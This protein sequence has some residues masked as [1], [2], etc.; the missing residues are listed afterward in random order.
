MHD[1]FGILRKKSVAEWLEVTPKQLDVM[2]KERKFPPPLDHH[3]MGE[4]WSKTEIMQWGTLGQEKKEFPT[5]KKKKGGEYVY[6]IGCGT[7]IK[8]GVADKPKERLSNLQT[9]NPIQ[10]ELIACIRGG[11]ELETQLHERFSSHRVRASGEWFHDCEEIRAFIAE[12]SAAAQ[13]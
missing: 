6:F 12:N 13:K 11:Y 1:M 2:V 10:L 4:V 5:K 8:I 7:H 3:V 9:A